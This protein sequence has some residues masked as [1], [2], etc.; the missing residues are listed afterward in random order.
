MTTV[1]EIIG[2]YH[3]DGGPV[4]EAKYVLGKLLGRAHCALCDITHSPVRRKP[5]WDEMVQRIA[6]PIELLHLNE[7]PADVAE[8]SAVVGTP[9][10]LG[11]TDSGEFVVLMDA[12]EL[13]RLGGSIEEFERLLTAALARVESGVA[14][15][16]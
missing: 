11:R 9:S 10:V 8:F 7:Q 6:R 2:I 12:D 5:A 4:G 3:A 1:T 15:G 14:L 16:N 13:E